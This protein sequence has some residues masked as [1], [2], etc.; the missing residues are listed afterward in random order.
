MIPS[1]A[2]IVDALGEGC[3]SAMHRWKR[4]ALQ[5]A[6]FGVNYLQVGASSWATAISSELI[7]LPCVLIYDE[8]IQNQ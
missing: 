5:A 4:W 2:D 7:R 8:R 3:S 1:E 6:A